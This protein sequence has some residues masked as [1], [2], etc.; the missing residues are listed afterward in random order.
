MV[1]RGKLSYNFPKHFLGVFHYFSHHGSSTYL[2]C[3]LTSLNSISEP[4]NPVCVLGAINECYEVLCDVR[5]YVSL[6]LKLSVNYGQ[7]V[8]VF[9]FFR[10]TVSNFDVCLSACLLL[11]VSPLS[12]SLRL[13]VKECFAKTAKLGTFFFSRF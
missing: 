6:C 2:F 11:C 7:T 12:L 3:T 8:A 1:L 13:L 10:E 5:M 4:N 9:V